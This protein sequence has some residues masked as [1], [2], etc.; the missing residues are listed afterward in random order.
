MITSW[1]GHGYGLLW[2]ERTGDGW[3]HHMI[4]GKTA[5]E[6]ETGVVFSQP[7]ALALADLNG[8]GLPDIV[9]GKRIWAHGPKGDPE[10]NAPAVLYAFEL[11]REDGRARFTAHL[12]DDDSGI[13]TQVVAA[14]MNG[15]GRPDVVVGNKKGLFIHLQKRGAP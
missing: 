10:P 7:H 9:T 3:R 4:A 8:D 12:I 11:R 5:E 14:D 1:E 6:G 2:H 13:G 15:D